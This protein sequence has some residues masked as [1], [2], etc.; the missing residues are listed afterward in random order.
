MYHLV[1][2]LDRELLYQGL[3][4]IQDQPEEFLEAINLQNLE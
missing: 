4:T 1:P 3:D 2:G